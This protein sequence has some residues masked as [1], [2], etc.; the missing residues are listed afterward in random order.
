MQ[1]TN[2]MSTQG[3][4]SKVQIDCRQARRLVIEP[5]ENRGNAINNNIRGYMQQTIE[6]SAQIRLNRKILR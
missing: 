6:M 1:Q 4:P 5:K 3:L 2:K